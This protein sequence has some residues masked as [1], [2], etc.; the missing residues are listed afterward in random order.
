MNKVSPE[1]FIRHGTVETFT[2]PAANADGFQ[3]KVVWADKIEPPR[4]SEYLLKGIIEPRQVSIWFGP[5]GNGKT[6][7]ML[8]LA[9]AIA[10]GREVFSRR[11]RQARTLYM[12]LEG[13]GG[14]DKRI[15]AML[16]RYGGTQAFGRSAT[17]VEL[18]QVDRN[19]TRINQAHVDALIATMREHSIKLLIIDTTNLTLGG[20]D[21][22]D[23]STMGLLMRAAGDIAEATDGHVALVAHSPKSGIDGGPRGGGAQK[24]NA[25]LV[26]SISGEDTFTASCFAPAGKIKDGAAFKLHFRLKTEK[27]LGVS[28]K[29]L[30]DDDGEVMTSCTVEEATAPAAVKTAKLTPELLGAF[31]EVCDLVASEGAVLMR[32]KVDM[33]AMRCVTR[34]QVNAHWIKTGRLDGEADKPQALLKR[35]QRLR[36]AL[37]DLGKIGMTNTHL[38]VATAVDA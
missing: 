5:A 17:L 29:P 22:N 26:V 10:Q 14:I 21:E 13:R 15:C 32:P 12:A 18:L 36:N 30:T 27:L 37:C 16:D 33:P 25:D 24:G 1:T 9:Y 38:W 11:V 31:K 7:L 35:A 19:V 2:P 8:H 34:S 4:Q 20:A 23:N 6:F 28:G 3:I